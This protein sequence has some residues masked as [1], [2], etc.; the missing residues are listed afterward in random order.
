MSLV[1]STSDP[2]VES[3]RQSITQAVLDAT[4]A[5]NDIVS[6]K[7]DLELPLSR[8]LRD[9]DFP[10]LSLNGLTSNVTQ[11]LAPSMTTLSQL[12][13]SPRP[14]GMAFPSPAF[15]PPTLAPSTSSSVTPIPDQPASELEVTQLV[16]ELTRYKNITEDQSKEIAML[17]VSCASW[18]TKVASL[19]EEI[20]KLTNE[21]QLV[22]SEQDAVRMALRETDQDTEANASTER[23]ATST[24]LELLTEELREARIIAYESTK[25]KEQLIGT[26]KELRQAL[27]ASAG[28]PEAVM[29]LA[30]HAENVKALLGAQEAV[31]QLLRQKEELEKRVMESEEREDVLCDEVERLEKELA[32][33]GSKFSSASTTVVSVDHSSGLASHIKEGTEPLLHQIDSSSPKDSFMPANNVITTSPSALDYAPCNAPS[34]RCASPSPL[35]PIQG[36]SS[37]SAGSTTSSSITAPTPRASIVAQ[38]RSAQKRRREEAMRSPVNIPL[39][40]SPRTSVVSPFSSSSSQIDP[41]PHDHQKISSLSHSHRSSHRRGLSL[42][43]PKSESEVLFTGDPEHSMESLRERAKLAESRVMELTSQV[44]E[45]TGHMLS[46]TRQLEQQQGKDHMHERKQSVDTLTTPS[47]GT[48]EFNHSDNVSEQ[49]TLSQATI[50]RLEASLASC[51]SELKQVTAA[52]LAKESLYTSLSN[53]AA[54]A[55][56]ELKAMTEAKEGLEEIVTTV[57]EH[58]RTAQTL[59]HDEQRARDMVSSALEAARRDSSEAKAKLAQALEAKAGAERLLKAVEDRRGDSVTAL[60]RSHREA[61]DA[62]QQISTLSQELAQVRA[63]LATS[64]EAKDG[65]SAVLAEVRAH[66]AT[67]NQNLIEEHAVRTVERAAAEETMSELRQELKRLREDRQ[68]L[69]ADMNELKSR[70][71]QAEQVGLNIMR[72]RCNGHKWDPSRGKGEMNT[73]CGNEAE[74]G[75]NDKD[76]EAYGS[77]EGRGGVAA[78]RISALNL[79][80]NTAW[81][82]ERNGEGEIKSIPSMID[83]RVVMNEVQSGLLDELKLLLAQTRAEIR[84]SDSMREESE[85][86][87]LE[88]ENR[89]RV[90]QEAMDSEVAER[91][92]EAEYALNE[93]SRADAAMAKLEKCGEDF[94][95][96]LADMEQEKKFAEDALME[97]TKARKQAE[98][99]V[100]QLQ[101]DEALLRQRVDA[102]TS[103]LI[104]AE[105]SVAAAEARAESA[106]RVKEEAVMARQASEK[107]RSDLEMKMRGAE[108]SRHELQLQLDKLLEAERVTRIEHGRLQEQITMLSKERAESYTRAEIAE[109]KLKAALGRATDAEDDADRAMEKVQSLTSQL[110]QIQS[111]LDDVKREKEAAISN[112]SVTIRSL[113]SKLALADQSLGLVQSQLKDAHDQRALADFAIINVEA[114]RDKARETVSELLVTNTSLRSQIDGLLKDVEDKERLLAVERENIRSLQLEQIKANDARSIQERFIEMKVVLEQR[115]DALSCREAALMMELKQFG[116]LVS[117]KDAELKAYSDQLIEKD[118]QIHQTSACLSVLDN[119]LQQTKAQLE[120]KEAELL[121]A[122]GDSS[123]TDAEITKL[124]T[125]LQYTEDRIQE[126][127]VRGDV[128]ERRVNEQTVELGLLRERIRSSE[129][130]CRLYE[131]KISEVGSQVTSLKERVEERENKVRE[132]EEELWEHVGKTGD[133]EMQLKLY[134]EK[135]KSANHRG[136]ELSKAMAEYEEE[137]EKRRLGIKERDDR[138][139]QLERD[140]EEIK[141]DLVA[142]SQ[143]VVDLRA[144]LALTEKQVAQ[145]NAN[146][147]ELIM[148]LRSHIQEE[149]ARSSQAEMKVQ[150]L[151]N[152][153][154]EL[155][156]GT[157]A[158]R[159]KVES[160]QVEVLHSQQRA[161]EQKQLVDETKGRVSHLTE[162]LRESNDKVD[163]LMQQIADLSEV[164]R[165]KEHELLEAQRDHHVGIETANQLNIRLSTLQSEF[166][167]NAELLAVLQ[168]DKEKTTQI[169]TH[170]DTEIRELAEEV[171]RLKQEVDILTQE[172]KNT[173]TSTVPYKE[174]IEELRLS[175]KKAGDYSDSLMISINSLNGQIMAKDDRLR[176]LDTELESKIADWELQKA[177]HALELSDVETKLKSLLEAKAAIE[178]R[179]E[180]LTE[181]VTRLR[182]KVA[183]LEDSETLK[184]DL[185]LMEKRLV[186]A[187]ERALAAERKISMA[188]TQTHGPAVNDETRKCS[189]VEDN[190][191]E[192][193]ISIQEVEIGREHAEQKRAESMVNDMVTITETQSELRIKELESKCI[194][195][196]TRLKEAES[197]VVDAERR[198]HDAEEL[199]R[200]SQIRV[201][202]LDAHVA[203]AAVR[204]AQFEARIEDL[205]HQLQATEHSLIE[206]R[207]EVN[208]AHEQVLDMNKR[209]Q[210]VERSAAATAEEAD[211]KVAAA[212][213]EVKAA[214][215]EAQA[216][217]QEFETLRGEMEA[218][219][220]RSS[221]ADGDEID[222]AH[223]LNELATTQSQLKASEE[224]GEAL[225]KEVDRLVAQVNLQVLKGESL[226]Q[227]ARRSLEETRLSLELK[228]ATLEEKTK[229]LE[230]QS[231][232][233]DVRAKELEEHYS[234]LCEKEAALARQEQSLNERVTTASCQEQTLVN[235]ANELTTRATIVADLLIKEISTPTGM[236]RKGPLKESQRTSVGSHIKA[237]SMDNDNKENFNEGMVADSLSVSDSTEGG[238]GDALVCNDIPNVVDEETSI[239]T[240]HPLDEFEEVSPMN[241]DSAP[242]CTLASEFN[243]VERPSTPT[244]ALNAA[245]AAVDAVVAA[246]TRRAS[247]AQSVLVIGEREELL[248]LEDTSIEEYPEPSGLGNNQTNTPNHFPT[249]ALRRSSV[250]SSKNR[251]TRPSPIQVDITSDREDVSY[252]EDRVPLSVTSQQATIGSVLPRAIDQ[253]PGVATDHEPDVP[254]VSFVARTSRS[255]SIMGA[256][257]EGGEVK[258]EG[259]GHSDGQEKIPLQYVRSIV[260]HYLMTD[261]FDHCFPVLAAV[262]KMS[263]QQVERIKQEYQRRSGWLPAIPGW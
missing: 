176:Q 205:S 260:M 213:N 218:I 156:E 14:T 10:S 208:L 230:E 115:V 80:D 143:Q 6:F 15:H 160:L 241:S 158:M 159:S 42:G 116:D 99:Q 57:G 52:L 97:S 226:I 92:R 85:A 28:G 175:L 63:M 45:L 73:S 18:Q 250:P 127:R 100:R 172:L 255:P 146:E 27:E 263:P 164:L 180:V 206:K 162:L 90:L 150:L 119:E 103:R 177:S 20:D 21:L 155:E 133:L 185:V 249:S 221:L 257:S 258:E 243:S 33:Y 144:A 242:A 209:L 31:V 86:L 231:L 196:E 254:H 188:H 8:P 25:E 4:A 161:I 58:L 137:L 214:R 167:R 198:A 22:R 16:A 26:V 190:P 136:D 111:A 224:R 106:L 131:T 200:K 40:S 247:L 117:A 128:A 207:S 134:K 245:V 178:K 113:E 262:L 5:L 142:K 98:S 232:A 121:S 261:D 174:E 39:P 228:S 204:I 12:A 3:R 23:V 105:T 87:A 9:S 186:N 75:D 68:V 135:T 60:N 82:V 184:A 32:T 47:H 65:L 124:K 165:Q 59:L 191:N 11:V 36:P 101:R 169:M 197:H 234:A 132:L 212:K 219:T 81:G 181:E 237:G 233:L 145:F 13:P 171:A 78:E 201:D 157:T 79:D 151:S 96:K 252:E 223:L 239:R 48:K 50:Q 129:D 107:S 248:Y 2:G 67:A 118:T 194:H 192:T 222:H 147:S 29:Q 173:S 122:S 93:K 189:D 193:V 19:Q 62:R 140:L 38:F 182:D 49:L 148:T 53:E 227:D 256:V 138:I 30:S 163:G 153:I 126:E 217:A 251:P 43:L 203:E 210:C 130:Q 149:K 141:E 235:R 55:H 69:Q 34:P 72:E 225:Q 154:T 199:Y 244:S 84:G 215:E 120:A 46:L 110:R 112:Y 1:G 66:L 259:S 91:Q 109:I 229:A 83:S 108:A 125:A 95:R 89:L 211:A 24:R 195:V 236:P 17:R 216:L 77:E 76:L 202:E 71:R 220:R 70:L 88:L 179:E 166:S 246:H 61:E 64:Q 104:A 35:Q 37:P 187:E 253:A 240:P 94:S 74:D 41:H 114:E 152:Q 183:Q 139:T 51:Q 54:I 102:L 238:M 123:L 170:K 7:N 44:T 56:A 168:A